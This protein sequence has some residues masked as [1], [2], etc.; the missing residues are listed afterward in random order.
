MNNIRQ[1][2]ANRESREESA[3]ERRTRVTAG[4]QLLLTLVSQ[5][6][7]SLPQATVENK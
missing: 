3:K 4:G 1:Q 7:Q 2:S 6:S 5:Q